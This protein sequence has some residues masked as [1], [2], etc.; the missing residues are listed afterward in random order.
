MMK[1]G[2]TVRCTLYGDGT[3]W[4]KVTV[5]EESDKKRR[6]IGSAEEVFDKEKVSMDALAMTTWMLDAA[7]RIVRERREFID[8][9]L[10]IE[11]RIRR[12]VEN[13]E[14]ELLGML[15]REVY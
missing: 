13:S 15:V 4:M 7:T 14:F 12:A 3:A 10:A 2:L 1:Y 11:Q 8:K 9:K 5:Y 6:A